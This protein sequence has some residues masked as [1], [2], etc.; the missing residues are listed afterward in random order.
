MADFNEKE[1]V[2][3][4]FCGKSE[5]SV[6]RM[7]HSQHAN[8]CDNCVELCYDL[9]AEEGLFTPREAQYKETYHADNLSKA[10]KL[11]KPAEICYRKP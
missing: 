6:E 1:P 2:R 4:S 8:I 11:L 7:L 3:C 10:P 5:Q 9:L